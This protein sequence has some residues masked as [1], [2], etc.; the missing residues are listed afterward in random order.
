M[1]A[2]RMNLRLKMAVLEK[3]GCQADFAKVCGISESNLSRIIRERLEPTPAT[4][5]MI[6]RVLEVEAEELFP[7]RGEDG[8]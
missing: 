6:A 4:R 2:G 3:Y 7:A 5:E 8:G 1:E